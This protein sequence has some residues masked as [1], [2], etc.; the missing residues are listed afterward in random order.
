[1]GRAIATNH[2]DI[3]LRQVV[4][5]DDDDDD[6]DMDGCV[7]GPHVRKVKNEFGPLPDSG[8]GWPRHAEDKEGSGA[9][10]EC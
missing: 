3:S 2:S 4:L 7:D 10:P 9:L 1:M 8:H 6:D 5:N